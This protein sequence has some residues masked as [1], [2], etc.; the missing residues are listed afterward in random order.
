MDCK[1][2]SDTLPFRG[3]DIYNM[4]SYVQEH[5]LINRGI[6]TLGGSTIPQCIMSNNKNEAQ[7]RAIMGGIYFIASY[8][9][10][11]LLIPVYN[12]HFLKNKGI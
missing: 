1:R 10:P 7:E 12:R 3:F 4:T 2:V 6:T 9:T 5:T 11:I 8:L